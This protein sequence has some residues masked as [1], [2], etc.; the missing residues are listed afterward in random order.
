MQ[1]EYQ[2]VYAGMQ[3]LVWLRGV[4]GEIGWHEGEPTSFFIDSQ[5]AKDLALKGIPQPVQAY[6]DQVP[7]D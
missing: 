3:E 5:S 4:W 6:R 7:L 1:T 2:V